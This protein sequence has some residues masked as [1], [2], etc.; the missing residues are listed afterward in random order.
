MFKT[1]IN[2]CFAPSQLV[3]VTRL[4]PSLMATSAAMAPATE[5]QQYISATWDFASLGPQCVFASRTTGGQVEHLSVFV[6]VL[7][8]LLA[9]FSLIFEMS[10]LH[11][12]ASGTLK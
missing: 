1:K 7:L 11:P 2:N 6:S 9:E 12:K 4:T 3:T 10:P 8:K 5:T